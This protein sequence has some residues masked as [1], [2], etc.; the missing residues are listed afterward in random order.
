[1]THRGRGRVGG[2]LDD[3]RRRDR[4]EDVAWVRTNEGARC[5]R[6]R[7]WEMAAWGAA[8]GHA[9]TSSGTQT[10]SGAAEHKGDGSGSAATSVFF[11]RTDHPPEL[12]A[13]DLPC[14]PNKCSRKADSVGTCWKATRLH[15]SRQHVLEGRHMFMKADRCW[16]ATRV[17]DGRQH[18]S[19][20]PAWQR[21]VRGQ[22][23]QGGGGGGRW[24]VHRTTPSPS[25][26][27]V[28]RR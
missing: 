8:A 19:D 7:T 9:Q 12:L 2:V 4:I 25:W 24:C 1:M 16:K 22:Q 21:A 27:K 13:V 10:R 3:R 20:G 14:G 15:E 18:V 6:L 17:H 28:T 5:L 26:S 23:R 11:P